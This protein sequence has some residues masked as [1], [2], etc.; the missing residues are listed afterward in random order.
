MHIQLIVW[1]SH[2]HFLG[3]ALS[4]SGLIGG[5]Q[6]KTFQPDRM[7]LLL[8]RTLTHLHIV[9][10]IHSCQSRSSFLQHEIQKYF[11]NVQVCHKCV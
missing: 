3:V 6:L 10:Q 8:E 1:I 4:L 2:D 9:I 11:S 5:G 7:S